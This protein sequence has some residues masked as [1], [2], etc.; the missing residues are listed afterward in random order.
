VDRF[1]HKPFLLLAG[2]AA[3]YAAGLLYYS[4]TT[5]FSWDEGFHLL[6]AQLISQGKRP[7][8]D[9]FFPQTPLNA[10]WSAFWMRLFGDTW[11]TV[12]AV[13]ALNTAAAMLLM[14]D[15]VLDRF[16]VERWRTAAAF[17]AFFAAACNDPIVEF[18]PVGQAY[19]LCLICLVAAFRFAVVAVSRKSVLASLATGFLAGAAAASSL[20]TIPVAPVMFLW[21]LY[22]NRVGSRVAKMLAFAAGS[23]VAFLPLLWLYLQSPAVVLFNVFQFNMRYR[24]VNW[25]DPF[26]QNVEAITA[27]LLSSQATV[28]GILA[29]AGLFFIVRSSGSERSI[30]A[31]FYLCGW[32]ALALGIHIATANPTFQRYFLF[33]APFLSIPAAA[34]AYWFGSRLGDPDRPRWAAVIVCAFFSLCLAKTV[35]DGH[36]SFGWSDMEKIAKKV[37]EV[38]PRG[39]AIWADEQVYFLT[40]RP[41]GFGMEHQNSH[42]LTEFPAEFARQLHILPWPEMKRLVSQGAFATVSECGETKRI[43]ELK[44]P[45]LYRKKEE[46]DECTIYWDKG[47]EAH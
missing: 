35:W 6:A 12:H 27:V 46:I 20:L 44:L 33:L 28:L 10:Y 29:L 23:V 42:K 11:H 39:A 5:A 43:G 9:F 7:Y 32:I 3:I 8:L 19:G 14:A 2:T 17:I 25:D 47:P 15:Y 16:P 40:R 22:H 18:G 37:D 41:P 34:G 24:W 38:T 30:R 45:K 21:I 36:D 4:Q 26:A 31:E 13:A 1:R